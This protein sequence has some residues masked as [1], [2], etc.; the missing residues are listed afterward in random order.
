MQSQ[1]PKILHEPQTPKI[2][3]EP[4]IEV[5]ALMARPR[6]VP[7]PAVW[8]ISSPALHSLAPLSCVLHS[9]SWGW[10]A[11]WMSCREPTL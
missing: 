4:Q 3:H 5:A 10:R 11:R 9:V 1:P 6:G 7:R 8:C 2:I